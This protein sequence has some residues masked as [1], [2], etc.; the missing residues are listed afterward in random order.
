MI[1]HA[2]PSDGPDIAA[3]YNPYIFET[4]ITFE[5]EGVSGGIMSERIATITRR[6][7]WLVWEENA[8]VEGYAYAAPW[9][10]RS[11]YRFACETSIYLAPSAQGRGVGR[12]LY[13]SLLQDLASR[14]LKTAIGGI[15]LPN[16]ASVALH[17]RLGFRKVGH[18]EAVGVKFGRTIDV[19]YWLCSLPQG[20]P[21]V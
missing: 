8:R 17:E 11:A 14:G 6:F 12:A 7:P 1:R 2:T 13:S 18:F 5:E 20:G 3:I 10:E 16:P 21:H 9:K 4:T 15:A 19:G